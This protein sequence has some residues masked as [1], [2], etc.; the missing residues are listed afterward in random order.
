MQ[1]ELFHASLPKISDMTWKSKKLVR[2][3]IAADLAAVMM[4][5]SQLSRGNFVRFMVVYRPGT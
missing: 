1:K 5:M 3:N 4:Y 2:Y